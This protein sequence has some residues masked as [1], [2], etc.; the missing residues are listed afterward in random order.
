MKEELTD[1][2]T[3]KMHQLHLSAKLQQFSEYQ[4]LQL[5]QVQDEIRFISLADMS[6]LTESLHRQMS[7]PNLMPYI[8]IIDTQVVHKISK[9]LQK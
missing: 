6:K 3:E 9:L 5:Q 4:R 1:I 2:V 7:D 8:E